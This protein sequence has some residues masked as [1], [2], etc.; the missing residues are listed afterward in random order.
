MV[1]GCLFTPLLLLLF[2]VAPDFFLGLLV[3]SG[4]GLQFLYLFLVLVDPLL[5]RRFCRFIH[6]PDCF[7][8][9]RLFLLLGR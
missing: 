6:A 2:S 8:R 9:I 3:V 7:L 4:K 1:F 5:K